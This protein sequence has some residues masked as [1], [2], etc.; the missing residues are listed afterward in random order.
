MK[1]NHLNTGNKTFSIVGGG[2]AGLT[3]AIALQKVGIQA[4]VFEGAPEFKPVGAGITLAYNAMKAFRRL[5]LYKEIEAAGHP[6]S[7]FEICD[8][9]GEIIIRPGKNPSDETI[10]YSIH[11]AELHQVLL[12]HLNDETLVKGKRISGLT[13]I[14]SGYKL[15]FED[16]TTHYTDYLIAADGIHSRIRKAVLPDSQLRYAGY[17][18]WRGIAQTNLEIRK[19][20]ETWGPNG[21]FGIVPFR[22]DRVYWFACKKTTVGDERLKSFGSKDILRLFKGYHEPIEDLIQNTPEENIIWSDIY[23][24]KPIRQ[25]A[26]GNLVLIGDAAHAATPNMGQGACQAIEDAVILAECLSEEKS[27]QEAFKTFEQK[28]MKRTRNIVNQSWNTGKIAQLENSYLSSV[29]NLLMRMVPTSVTDK[30]LKKLYEVEFS[31]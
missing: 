12:S 11:R 20:T 24:L 26:F 4:T 14:D 27:V 1:P 19:A 3:A 8:E 18:C 10:I 13:Q 22:N 5:G 16:G 29:R 31:I 6:N 7:T 21:R 9:K 15:D 28:R 23:D 2:I 17:T 25:F 30:Q